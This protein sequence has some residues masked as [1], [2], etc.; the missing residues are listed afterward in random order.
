MKMMHLTSYLRAGVA[1][2]SLAVAAPLSAFT[3]SLPGVSEF[4]GW[5]GLNNTNYTAPTYTGGFMNADA[6]W[7]APVQSNV[8]GS[9]GF[10]ALDKVSGGGYFASTSIYSA[11]SPG[12]FSITNSNALAGL[13][14]VVFQLEAVSTDPI[15]PTLS[16][17]GGT[18]SLEADLTWLTLGDTETSFGDST[19]YTFQW[20]LSTLAGITD[21][22]ITYSGP[23]HFSQVGMSL[24][25]GDTF[26]PV[27]AA[28]PEPST[29]AAIFGSLAL[30]TVA[31]R[32]RMK[33]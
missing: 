7:G 9:A 32:R 11:F 22:V 23:Q 29:Y 28:V 31:A 20:D 30:L 2:L 4:E 27:G 24:Y 3:V 21:Y 19:I 18:Q 17:N 15:V 16:F 13:E 1:L 6:D 14:T 5:E 33:R 8:S 26:A 12:T 25:S 10:A